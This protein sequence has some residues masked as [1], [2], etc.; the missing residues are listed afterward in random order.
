MVVTAG[1]CY[2]YLYYETSSKSWLILAA[3]GLAELLFLYHYIFV[4]RFVIMQEYST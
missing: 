4:S 3:N 1:R 2:T